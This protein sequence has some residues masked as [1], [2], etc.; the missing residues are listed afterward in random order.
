MLTFIVRVCFCARR[1]RATLAC[2]KSAAA[3]D[4]GLLHETLQDYDARLRASV[5]SHF[6]FS[7]V[8]FHLFKFAP[9]F[10]FAM[11]VR[12]RRDAT[13]MAVACLLATSRDHVQGKM[14]QRKPTRIE[15]K[16]E[17]LA[18]YAEARKKA[19]LLAQ[20]QKEMEL[21]KAAYEQQQQ[22]RNIAAS[23]SMLTSTTSFA[24]SASSSTLSMLP[25][26]G[27]GAGSAAT[28]K[29]QFPFLGAS[30]DL[31]TAERIGFRK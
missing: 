22:Q 24:S 30:S 8:P 14:L 6:P 23:T 11:D 10:A 9:S 21:A 26:A 15:L 12:I 19:Q 5:S 4:R 31:T 2:A 27:A 17:D 13:L 28:A 16:P 25:G 29:Q 20:R 7:S 1:T 18:E 3:V